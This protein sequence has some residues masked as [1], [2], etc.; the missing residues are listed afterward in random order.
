MAAATAS[1]SAAALPGGAVDSVDL[2]RSRIQQHLRERGIFDDL[3][4]IVSD[5]LGTSG[6]A[7]PSAL[8]VEKSAVR[9]GIADTLQLRGAARGAGATAVRRVPDDS[10]DFLLQC[11]L[12]G[13]RAF[14]DT[15]SSFQARDKGML[16][17]SLQLG[18]SRFETAPTP[19]CSEPEL[20]GSFHFPLPLQVRGQPTILAQRINQPIHNGAV[21]MILSRESYSPRATFARWEARL[22]PT[23]RSVLTPTTPASSYSAADSRCTCC[24]SSHGPT[25]RTISSRRC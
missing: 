1:S 9:Q 18:D 13:G 12:L 14:F 17:V 11:D 16:R 23:L 19:F 20:G 4:L 24:C 25:A 10:D 2:V 5:A 7:G 6:D 15:G 22:W 21:H 8:A 3:R